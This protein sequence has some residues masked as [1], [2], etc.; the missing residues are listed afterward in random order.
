M[1]GPLRRGAGGRNGLTEELTTGPEAGQARA[2][3]GPMFAILDPGA[4]P[5]GRGRER[6]QRRRLRGQQGFG[7]LHVA[8]LIEVRLGDPLMEINGRAGRFE[9]AAAVD[10]VEGPVQAQAQPLNR[11]REVQRDR[12]AHRPRRLGGAQHRARA[13]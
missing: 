2:D 1:L 6:W 4:E 12:S 11:Y 10:D 9:D 5:L 3:R 13:R 7:P 8:F